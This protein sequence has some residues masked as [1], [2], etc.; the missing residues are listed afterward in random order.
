MNVA[1]LH[2]N[3]SCGLIKTR[4][5]LLAYCDR[6]QQG[7]AHPGKVS[8]RCIRHIVG[9]F[10]RRFLLTDWASSESPEMEF[11]AAQWP[12]STGQCLTRKRQGKRART[13]TDS[14]R[15]PTWHLTFFEAQTPAELFKS[16]D[17]HIQ[18]IWTDVLS[19]EPKRL[20]LILK[21]HSDENYGNYVLKNFTG[22]SFWVKMV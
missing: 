11:L 6:S 10:P 1:K 20:F 16:A 7:R 13:D 17:N 21:T 8:Q 4:K 19:G 14:T 22:F 5:Y 15:S 3:F 18:M 12:C 2:K 9:G